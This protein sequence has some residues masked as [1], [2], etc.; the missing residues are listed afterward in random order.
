MRQRRRSRLAL[1]SAAAGLTCLAFATPA[2]AMATTPLQRS[3]VPLLA[4]DSDP[5]GGNGTVKIDDIP[6]DG[7]ISN[8]PH[9]GCTFAVKFFDFDEGEHANIVFS[10]QQKPGPGIELLRRDNVL[11]STDAAT[12][13]KPDPDEVFTFSVSQLGLGAY[14]P[15]NDQGYH[16]KLTVERIG[17]PGAGK[18]KV[19]WVPRC[20]D[21]KSPSSPPPSNPSSP[22]PS[23][24]S[25]GGGVGGGGGSL[26]IT[27]AAI[28]GLVTVGLGLLGAGV[29]LVLLRR[30]RDAVEFEA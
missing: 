4:P 14:K 12:G 18:H 15:Q 22:P 8:V 26:P 27:G 19:F 29:T 25:N 6:V 23:S 17:A 16:I 1:I 20:V 10:L 7:D 11:V 24:P 3:N 13:G 21:K 30:R 2:W 9:V 28:G 5:R